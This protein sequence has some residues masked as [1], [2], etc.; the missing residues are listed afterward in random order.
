MVSK[1][2][3]E[4]FACDQN[5]DTKIKHEEEKLILFKQKT[6]S[7]AADDH[8]KWQWNF[9]VSEGWVVYYETIEHTECFSWCFLNGKY[10]ICRGFFDWWIFLSFTV[11]VNCLLWYCVVAIHTVHLVT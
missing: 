9:C 7:T 1:A 6:H 3:T 4:R 10:V 8:C 5:L 2:K 11:F